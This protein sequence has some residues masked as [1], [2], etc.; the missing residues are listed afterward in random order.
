MKK[1]LQ[2]GFVGLS[3]VLVC[4]SSVDAVVIHAASTSS[5]D[6]QAA[7]DLALD[8][9]TV[10]VPAGTATWLVTVSV[11]NKGIT[12]QGAGVGLTV[13]TDNTGN[14]F[15]EPALWIELTD[16]IGEVRVTGFTFLYG[17]NGVLADYNGAI[18][19]WGS[20]EHVRIDHNNFVD[21]YNRAV[22]FANGNTNGLIDHCVFQR[23]PAATDRFQAINVSSNGDAAWLRPL[24]LGSVNALYA[25]DNL[26]DFL[27]EG[28]AIDSHSGGRYVF[29]M[30]TIRNAGMLNHGLDTNDRSGHSFEVYD[31]IFTYDSYTF[32]PIGMRGGT[33]VL[34]RNTLTSV[35]GIEV[36]IALQH[37]RSCV[38]YP[39]T[40]GV[41]CNGSN[42]IDGNEDPSG[43]PCKDQPGRTTGQVLS[44]VYNWQNESDSMN[45]GMV[46]FDPWMCSNPG[47]ADHVQEGRDF[48]NDTFRPGFVPLPYPHPWTLV[49]HPGQQRSLDL[50]AVLTTDQIDLTWQAVTGAASYQVLRDW[51]EVAVTASTGWG[52]TQPPGEH[53]YMVYAL[54]GSGVIL[55]AEGLLDSSLL[56]ADGFESGDTS[57]WFTSDPA[58]IGDLDHN[59]F[60]Q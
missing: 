25:E 4:Q 57:A 49:D 3:I 19:V 2:L 11:V 35:G 12:L 51:E 48:F 7:I 46:L 38:D 44:P 42:P 17:L 28:S 30:N 10:I 54:D 8:G 20:G 29:R 16:G 22:N 40:H 5:A 36:P 1:V 23:T 59:L 21:F 6:V 52:D 13:V 47:M 15:D 26:F 32:Q 60:S 55:A 37:Y 34:F 14:E 24:T 43:Y 39:A 50:Q 9:D 33:G 56:F 27:G 58:A 31:N 18:A 41:R 53:V 45:V